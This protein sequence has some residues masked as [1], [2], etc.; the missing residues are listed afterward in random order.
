MKSADFIHFTG[1]AEV[2]GT[3]LAEYGNAERTQFHAV[4]SGI[5]RELAGR[6]NGRSVNVTEFELSGIILGYRFR[7]LLAKRL[8][9]AFDH[10]GFRAG[11]EYKFGAP[12]VEHLG[13]KERQSVDPAQ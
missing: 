6:H 13:W 7:T 2:L 1:L 4:R 10:R 8:S 11:R 12:L 5:T 9:K 3:G